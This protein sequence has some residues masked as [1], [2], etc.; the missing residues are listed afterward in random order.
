MVEYKRETFAENQSA[1]DFSANAFY[2]EKWD[3]NK[4]FPEFCRNYGEVFDFFP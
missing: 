2:H 1:V 4:K 3:L